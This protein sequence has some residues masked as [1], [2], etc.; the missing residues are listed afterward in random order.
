MTKHE[1]QYKIDRLQEQISA[2]QGELDCTILAPSDIIADLLHSKSHIERS[3]I[4]CY[5]VTRVEV[6]F[7]LY[8]SY[9]SGDGSLDLIYEK[10][11]FHVIQCAS[12]TGNYIRLR[13]KRDP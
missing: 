7:K 4:E 5:R 13:F 6:W 3:K 9:F 2:L 8:T 11:G 1:I 12:G 10:T